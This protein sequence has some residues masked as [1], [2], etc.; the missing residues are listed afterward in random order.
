MLN[1]LFDI[2]FRL[3]KIDRNGDP[4]F[5][6]N[7]IV[8]WEDF[9]APLMILREKERKSVAGAKGYDL[10]MM[11]KILVLQSFP[12]CNRSADFGSS[13]FHAFSWALHRR[14]SA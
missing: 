10:V 13:V 6:L 1:G 5:R 3:D 11:F 4:L 12:R 8:P 9:R 7:Q 14:Q 2:Q